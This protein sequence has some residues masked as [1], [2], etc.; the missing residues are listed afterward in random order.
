MLTPFAGDQVDLED[1]K[2]EMPFYEAVSFVIDY[3]L[4]YPASK[5]VF[6]VDD[7]AT[8]GDAAIALYALGIE[9]T[10]DAALALSEISSYGIIPSSALVDDPLTG[11]AFEDYL[12]AFSALVG[13][14]YEKTGA[15]DTVI[16]RGELAE[17][18]ME[19]TLPLLG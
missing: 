10:K 4:M 14:P 15:E 11:A 13:V 16:T 3:N 1:V 7:T 17:M 18:I 12:A 9:D 6:G 2:E 8:A 19:Y 5:T